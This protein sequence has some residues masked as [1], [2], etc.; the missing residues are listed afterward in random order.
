MI[1]GIRGAT[2]VKTDEEKLVLSATEALLKEMINVNEIN[3]ENVTS[4]FISVTPD[5]TSTFPAK[6]VRK[7]ENWTHV[8][9]MCMQ[10][11][12]VKNSLPLCIRIMMHVNTSQKQKAV[13]HIY[14]EEAVQLRPDLLDHKQTNGK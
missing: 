5:I 3:P 8:P 4:L 1:R 10:E 12:A 6:A 2:T 13:K 7:F 11:I 14:H 9:V